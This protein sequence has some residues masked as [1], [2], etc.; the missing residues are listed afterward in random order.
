MNA[1]AQIC[2]GKAG[3]RVVVLT[4]FSF[5]FFFLINLTTAE[6]C[7]RN[8]AVSFSGQDLIVKRWCECMHPSIF[9]D[10]V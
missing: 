10:A 4:G 1:E 6:N 9:D 8:F 7:A 5:L 2:E 3:V